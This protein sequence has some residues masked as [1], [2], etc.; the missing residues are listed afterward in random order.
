MKGSKLLVTRMLIGALMLAGL[1]VV[2][3]QTAQAA[4][5]YGPSCAGQSASATGCSQGA[6]YL[7]TWRAWGTNGDVAAYVEVYH[8][9]A[10]GSAWLLVAVPFNAYL[11]TVSTIW[12]PGKASQPARPGA[13]AWAPSPMVDD[14]PG[15]QT[16]FGTQVYRYGAWFQWQQ[17]ACY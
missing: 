5:C 8:S 2:G 7:G 17:H 3:P 4:S 16:C 15:V 11:G 9:D 13:G 1:S 14:R 12:N 6:R 10:C